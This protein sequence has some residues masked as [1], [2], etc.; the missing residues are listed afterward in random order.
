MFIVLRGDP[1]SPLKLPFSR[2]ARTPRDSV[3]FSRG[4]RTPSDSIR[5]FGFFQTDSMSERKR[6]FSA[7]ERLAAT[8][9]S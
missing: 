4:A 2:G 6:V 1:S 7:S 9:S 3:R 8:V 5:Q